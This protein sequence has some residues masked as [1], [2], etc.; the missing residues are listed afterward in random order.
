MGKLSR[1]SSGIEALEAARE[2]QCLAD[3]FGVDP[4]VLDEAPEVDPVDARER[5]TNEALCKAIGG[6]G[7]CL[8]EATEAQCKA[9]CEMI[10]QG[11][12]T[13]AGIT[14]ALKAHANVVKIALNDRDDTAF[15]ALLEKVVALFSE[16]QRI[17]ALL[18][19]EKEEPEEDDRPVIFDIE[20]DRNGF[21]TTVTARPQ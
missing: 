14:K 20:R 9:I 5:E 1:I 16:N 4:S 3:M 15:Q 8:E 7:E 10:P 17:I 19:A 2:R 18:M 6:L 12:V 11:L 21:M 13:D